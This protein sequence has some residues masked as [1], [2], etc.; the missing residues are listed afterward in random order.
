M[1]QLSDTHYSFAG[2][3]VQPLIAG[4]DYAMDELEQAALVA[5]FSMSAHAERQILSGDFGYAMDT[6]ANPQLVS[7]LVNPVQFLQNWLPGIVEAITAAREIDNI[8]GIAGIGAWE[9]EMVVQQVLELSGAPVAYGDFTNIPLA[10]WNQN[11]VTRTNVRFELGAEVGKLEQARSARMNVDSGG[12]K[13]RSCSIQLEIQR[14]AV[15]FYGYNAGLN[16][17]YGLLNDPSLP[18]Y[19]TVANN[20]TPWNQKTFQQL[21]TDLLTALQQLR[22]QTQGRVNPRK[23]AITLTVSTNSVDALTRTTDQGISVLNWLNTNFPNV[24]VTDAV[25]L[26]GANGGLN[27]FYMFA[28]SVSDSGTD[29]GKTWVQ[30]VATKLQLL[31]MQQLSKSYIEDY[32][33]ATAGVM[34]KRPYAV[35]RYSGL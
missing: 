19:V 25:Q 14:N 31:G 24:R 26:N 12:T 20:G 7:S 29:D 9:D 16:L 8:I 35:V 15:G 27:V 33:N 3:N 11:F 6:I 21:Q 4:T 13:R 28:D 2:K 30:P 32:S 5:G 34:C 10:N 22:V 17:T 1:K 23:D 18:A